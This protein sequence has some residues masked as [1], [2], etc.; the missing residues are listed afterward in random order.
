MNAVLKPER[1]VKEY[2][3]EK[4]YNSAEKLENES[5]NSLLLLGTR[6]YR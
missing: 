4:G 6:H 5:Y 3:M 1:D 2:I